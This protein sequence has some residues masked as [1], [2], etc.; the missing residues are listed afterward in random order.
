MERSTKDAWLQGPSDLK[1][2]DVENVPVPGKSVRVRALPA[3]YAADLQGHIKL[4]TEGRE[5]VMKIDVAEMELL[6]FVHGVTDPVFSKDEARQIQ[7]RFGSSF[8]KT[9]EKID[10]LSGIDKEAIEAVEQRFPAVNGGKEGPDVGNGPT[11]RSAKPDVP[12]RARSR[13][14][15]ARG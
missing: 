12:V 11:G 15:N 6:Q 4:V 2:A 5:Q 9:V 14:R 10:E 8:R 13:A 7:E 1:E 3:R